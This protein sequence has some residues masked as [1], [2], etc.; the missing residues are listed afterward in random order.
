MYCITPEIMNT[1]KRTQLHF[2]GGHTT[3]SEISTISKDGSITKINVIYLIV[4]VCPRIALIGFRFSL[5]TC[6]S[7]RLDLY[8]LD[9]KPPWTLLQKSIFCHRTQSSKYNCDSALPFCACVHCCIFKLSSRLFQPYSVPQK[10]SVP[11]Y[12]S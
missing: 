1:N 11:S 3:S 12:L 9:H 6:R 7:S 5:D 10:Q 2:G 8:I 4:V